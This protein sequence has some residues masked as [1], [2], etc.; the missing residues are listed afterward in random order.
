MAATRITFSS[1]ET[2]QCTY[3]V[4]LRNPVYFNT[5]V[6]YRGENDP[7]G[8]KNLSPELV[9]CFIQSERCTKVWL[10]RTVIS[11]T[12]IQGK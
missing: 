8:L 11:D 5:L 1:F 6:V 12:F 9:S 7:Q 10:L 3:K 2:L 4:K